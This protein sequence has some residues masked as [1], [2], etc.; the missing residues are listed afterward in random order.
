[1]K[2]IFVLAAISAA[3][4]W[5]ACSQPKD[6]YVD[7]RTGEKIEIEKDPVTGAW[8][9]ADSKEPV[10]IYVNTK[11]NDTI[12]GKTGVVINGHV[13]KDKGVYWYEKDSDIGWNDRLDE[14]DKYKSGDYKEKVESDGDIKIKDGDK[15]IK[16]DGETGERKVKN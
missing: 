9:N 6:A 1:M 7:L 4:L 5:S 13:V 16:I 12:F 8:L 10:Y 2:K 3:L 15:K 14:D 11:N